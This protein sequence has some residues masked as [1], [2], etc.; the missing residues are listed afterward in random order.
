[1]RSALS[2]PLDAVVAAA[3]AAAV[4]VTVPGSM[5]DIG[6]GLVAMSVTLNTRRSVLG[7]DVDPDKIA[8]ARR[9][10]AANPGL[11]RTHFEVVEQ[12][13][14]PP[15]GLAVVVKE[16]DDHPQWKRRW[17]KLRE[18]VS[19]RSIT[20]APAGNF[21]PPSRHLVTSWLCTEGL[22]TESVRLD[23]WQPWPHYLVVGRRPTG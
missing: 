14:T 7:V 21:D 19:V 1:M 11:A 13:W 5:V 4:D 12:D 15:P 8:T 20:A 10:A 2:A 18:S 22:D 16:T 6:T 17:T 9:V 23:R 3:V